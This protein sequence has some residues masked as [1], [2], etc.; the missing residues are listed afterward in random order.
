MSVLFLGAF[1]GSFEDAEKLTVEGKLDD[2]LKVYKSIL[3]RDSTSARAY[4]GIGLALWTGGRS[5]QAIKFYERALEIQP[6]LV[7]AHTDLSIIY[8]AL[9]QH[10]L[11][12]Q[13]AEKALHII[14]FKLGL[15]CSVS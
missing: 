1:S 15:P 5:D 7:Q 13:Y 11:A 6:E 12:I 10:K 4:R 8:S 2:A 3:D 14:F 9:Y